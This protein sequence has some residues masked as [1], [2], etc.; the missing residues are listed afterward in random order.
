MG[1]SKSRTQKDIHSNKNN[2]DLN[3]QPTFTSQ[4][5]KKGQTKPKLKEILSDK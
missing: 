1:C 2:K 4:R 3:K 5:T